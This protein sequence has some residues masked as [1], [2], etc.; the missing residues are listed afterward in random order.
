M[1]DRRFLR[2]F[3]I[4]TAFAVMS[5]VG[6]VNRPTWSNIRGGDVV[7]LIGTG[8]CLGVAL[9]FLLAYFREGP[10]ADGKKDR[11]RHSS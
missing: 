7:H 4:A 1:K 2:I 5:F 6:M 11:A 10:F 3:F 8:M 9:V